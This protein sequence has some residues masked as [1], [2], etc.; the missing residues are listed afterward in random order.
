MITGCDGTLKTVEAFS[1]IAPVL[2]VRLIKLLCVFKVVGWQ[3][4]T[5]QPGYY[6][7]S[8]IQEKITARPSRNIYSTGIFTVSVSS[9]IGFLRCRATTDRPVTALKW[10]LGW[11]QRGLCP[12]NV[13]VTYCPSCPPCREIAS[14][15]RGSY[16]HLAKFFRGDGSRTITRLWQ[17]DSQFLFTHNA[18][19]SGCEPTPDQETHGLSSQSARTHS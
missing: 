9:I 7:V 18:G 19:L 8:S 11:W 5:T 17:Y 16:C 1:R 14:L 6:L 12:I 4:T 10:L 2:T 15:T 13:S 3:R